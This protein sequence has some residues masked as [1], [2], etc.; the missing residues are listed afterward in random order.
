MSKNKESVEF[1]KLPGWLQ[2]LWSVDPSIARKAGK[3]ISEIQTER[4]TDLITFYISA[5]TIRDDDF[6]ITKFTKEY[7]ERNPITI[8]SK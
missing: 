3:Y 1:D 6:K 4:Y 5:T 2:E 7:I 8:E